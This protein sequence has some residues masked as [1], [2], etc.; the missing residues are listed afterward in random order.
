MRRRITHKFN[1]VFVKKDGQHFDSKL[2][3][4]YYQQLE[5]RKKSGEVLFFLSQV[6]FK[7]PGGVKYFCDFLV[8]LSN[9]EVEVIDCKGIE[10]DV[11]KVKKKQVEE[12]YPIEIKIIRDR[13]F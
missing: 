5:L 10:T 12:I 7:L 1:N 9:G 6:P 13:D 8:F 4:R 2:E 3:F 11:F